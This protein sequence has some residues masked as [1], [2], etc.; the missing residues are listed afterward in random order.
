MLKKQNG[1]R[2]IL[3]RVH[4]TVAIHFT[5]CVQFIFFKFKPSELSNLS[6]KEGYAVECE[7]CFSKR[8]EMFGFG[9]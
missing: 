4:D 7:N 2:N 5:V 3:L 9:S 6:T 8:L 1:S